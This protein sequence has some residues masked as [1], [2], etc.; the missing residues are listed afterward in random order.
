MHMGCHLTKIYMGGINSAE[1]AKD[2]LANMDHSQ[3][4]CGQIPQ[5]QTEACPL[6][7]LGAGHHKATDVVPVLTLQVSNSDQTRSTQRLSI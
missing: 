1:T 4:G 5:D 7:H 3:K 2:L 6:M